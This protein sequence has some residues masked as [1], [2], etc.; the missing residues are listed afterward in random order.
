MRTMRTL[1]AAV[2]LTAAISLA[3]CTGGTV[4]GGGETPAPASGDI[5]VEGG[6]ITFQTWSLKNDRFTPYFESVIAAFE[7]DNPGVKVNWIDQPGDGYED[8]ILQQANSGELPD[9]INLPPEF[10]YKLAQVDQLVDLKAADSAKVGEYVEGATNAYVYPN[11]DGVYGYPWYLGTDLNWYNTKMLSEAGVDATKL[12]TDLDALFAMASEVAKATNGNVKMISDVPRTGTLSAAGVEI[13][14]DGQFVFNTPEAVKVV[15]RYK[16]AYED[17]AMPAEAL[18]ADYLGNKTL[19]FQGKTAWTTGAAG[20]ASDLAKEAPTLVPDTVVTPRI[21]HPPLFIQGIS[22]AK[23]SKYP[24]LALKFAQFVTNTDNQVEFVKIAQGFFPGTK[25]AN[26]NPDT[27]TS[28]IESDLQKVATEAAAAAMGDATPEYP[29]QFTYDMDTYLKQQM[30]LAV[31]G[32]IGIQE[33]LDKAVE[34]A[35]KNLVK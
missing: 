7:K 21:G 28:V 2:A 16:K 8:K 33:A 27:F 13:F 25:E 19:Y 11:I 10:A 24:E 31:K 29:I 26:A 1:T 17:G 35:N 12:P 15:E 32:E 6:E 22:V 14:K 23:T 3:A 20:F 18:N 34:Y 4:T 9:V 30:A 5:A